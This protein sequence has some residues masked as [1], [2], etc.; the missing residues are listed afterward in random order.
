MKRAL[1]LVDLQ[2]DFLAARGLEP[3]AGELIRRT[4]RL[5][6][7]WRATGQPVLHIHTLV[8]PGGADAMPHWRKA[9]K[10]RCVIGTAGAEPPESLAPLSH[11]IVVGKTFYSGFDSP[12]LKRDLKFL[13]VEGVV[14]A[15]LHLHACIRETALGAYAQHLSVTIAEDAVASDDP[16]QAAA[17]RRWLSARGVDFVPAVSVL[18][19]KKPVYSEPRPA[20]DVRQACASARAAA[21]PWAERPWNERACCLLAA[22]DRIEEQG[23][24]LARLIAWEVGKPL[25]DATGEVRRTAALLRN[26]ARAEPLV[27]VPCQD[28]CWRRV[29]LGVVALLTP[30]NNPVAIPAGKIGPALAYGNAVVWKPSPAA[31]ESAAALREVFLDAGVPRGALELVTGDNDVSR[32]LLEDRDVDALSISGSSSAGWTIQEVAAR[33]RLPVQAELGGNNGAIVWRD[34]D[35]ATAADAIARG[36]FSFAG[37]RCTS[38]RRAIVDR[39]ILEPF[40]E[41]LAEATGRLRLGDPLDPETDLGPLVSEAAAQRVESLV[42]RSQPA[43]RLILT[44][45]GAPVAD[46]AYLPPSILVAED[47]AH[48]IVQEETFGPV[49]VVQPAASF[50]EALALLDGVPQGL[51]AALFSADPEHRTRFLAEARAGILKLDRSTVDASAEAPFGGFKGSGVGPPEHGPGNVEFYTR[52][53]A[54]YGPPLP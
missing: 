4:A 42:A 9:D 51:I 17:A 5:L 41:Q 21:R 34:A 23:P 16:L 37:Q 24:G 13:C 50:D 1:L 52:L 19:E 7:A 12:T 39:E 29:P 44:S 25:R 6:E 32:L 8:Q 14:L 43:C 11:E 28:G 46:G 2:N 15:G 27:A 54:V 47:P 45:L 33:R 31:L 36:A 26:A 48:E 53:Q 40:L 3:S 38:N 30:W 22:A 49:L 18:E 10:P 35:L 20:L